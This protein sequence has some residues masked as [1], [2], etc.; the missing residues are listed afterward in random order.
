VRPGAA[1]VSLP[2]AR[3]LRLSWLSRTLC[4]RREPRRAE[5]DAE[6]WH[7]GYPNPA[8]SAMRE[9]DGAWM[10]RIVARFD[11]AAIAAVVRE[12]RLSSP[13][14]RSELEPIL[15]GR[16]DKILQRYLLRLSFAH[17]RAH[18]RP[19]ALRAR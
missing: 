9:T 18:V 17:R 14:A 12:G 2:C 5:F 13:I 4:S 1:S 19:R 7:V 11:D 3:A 10:A 16:R 8:F 15:R 6:H